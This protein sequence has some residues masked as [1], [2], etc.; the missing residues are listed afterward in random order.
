[1]THH[2][3]SRDPSGFR[4]LPAL[5]IIVLSW[6]A[7]FPVTSVDAYYHLATGRRI[8][9]ERS[10]PTRG[11][12]S[13][14][15][16][17]APWHDQEW[18]FQVIA[19]FLGGPER[20]GDGVWVQA[21]AGTVRLILMRALCLGL[22]LALLSAMMAL[23]GVDALSRALGLILAAFLTF[24]NLFWAIRPQIF[25]YLFLA[26]LVYLVEWDRRGARWAGAATLAVIAIWAN[27][28]GMFVVGIAL[29]ASEAT[30]EWIDGIRSGH[31]PVPTGRTRRM[32]ILTLLAPAAACLNPHGYHQLIHPF[33]YVARPEI[34]RGNLEWTRP[35]YLHLPLLVLT[36]AILVVALANRPRIPATHVV[37]CA[38]FGA[39]AASA[40]RHLPMAALVW[41][42]VAGASLTEAAHRGGWR[43]NLLPTGPAWGRP[44][45]RLVAGAILA[46]T[47]VILSGAKFVGIRPRFEERPVLPMPETAVRLIASH[48]G[49]GTVFNSYRFGG[50]L[51]F[52]LY[53][54]EVAFM[55]GRNDLYG[56][57][58]HEV[59]NPILATRPG[60]RSLWARAVEEHDVRWVLVD[61]KDPLVAALAGDAAW[62]MA[63]DGAPAVLDGE[64]GR[65]GVVLMPRDDPGSRQWLLPALRAAERGHGAEE[66]RSP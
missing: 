17:Q 3:P 20:D 13:A 30:G 39:L 25:S 8:L 43:R 66:D 29:L 31:G 52:R 49:E 38:L 9:E 42:P 48:G 60:W 15:L 40:I 57:F 26:I 5:T 1:M 54:R 55:D 45:A 64:P 10:I 11:V 16:G 14:T 24:G 33:L 19:A 6:L 35:D 61:E 53:P 59:Y 56:A 58:R 28:H 32:A 22:T 34:Y 51:M 47:F 36:A 18:G 46:A 4:W 62:L 37:R 27:I 21:P 12:G 23:A 44:A 50:F 7:L 65:D 2:E 63:A 41:V